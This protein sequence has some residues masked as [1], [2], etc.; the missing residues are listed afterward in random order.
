M[1][2]C[3]S[4]VRRKAWQTRRA[5]YGKCGHGSSYSRPPSSLG[6]HALALIFR[7]HDEMVLSE[8]QC[9]KALNLERVEFRTLRDE[10][11]KAV[12]AVLGVG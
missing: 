7:L 9:C 4:D 1:S 8:G 5:K 2:G 3:V 11:A 10:Y 6:R 12:L